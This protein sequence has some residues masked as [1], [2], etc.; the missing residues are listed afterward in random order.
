M[1]HLPTLRHDLDLGWRLYPA[2]GAWRTSTAPAFVSCRGPWWSRSD[3]AW[4]AGLRGRLRLERG[5]ARCHV[6]LWTAPGED[7]CLLEGAGAPEDVGLRAALTGSPVLGY[8]GRGMLTL[9]AV[10]DSVDLHL[11]PSVSYDADLRVGL[12]LLAGVR[13]GR[14][15]FRGGSH[16][17][18]LLLA[19]QCRFVP[20]SPEWIQAA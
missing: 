3:R 5:T 6:D 8:T 11:R 20:D 9:G 19:L 17:G 18:A 10:T 15:A 4:A 1:S 13:A 2:Y 7:A 12:E 14:R 16:R